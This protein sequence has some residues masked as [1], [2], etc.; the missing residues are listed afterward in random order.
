[1]TDIA[2]PTTG[3]NSALLTSGTHVEIKSTFEPRWATGFEVIDH[4][5]AGY[6]VRRLSD[7]EE[8]PVIFD[9]NDVRSEKKRDYWWY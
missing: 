8:L 9:F 2:G 6:R 4:T 5:D 1:M 3:P 7:G